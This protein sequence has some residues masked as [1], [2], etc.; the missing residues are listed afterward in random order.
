MPGLPANFKLVGLTLAADELQDLI[1]APLLH[2]EFHALAFCS[3]TIRQIDFTGSAARFGRD[4]RGVD[5]PTELEFLTPILTLL[6][7]GSTKCNHLLLSGNVL[8]TQDVEEI[9]KSHLQP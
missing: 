2:Q 1:Q 4:N 5:E 6:R 9:G 7:S 3:G 8:R